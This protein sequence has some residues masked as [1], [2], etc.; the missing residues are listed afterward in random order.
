MSQFAERIQW[1]IYLLFDHLLPPLQLFSHLLHYTFHLHNMVI[2]G[3]SSRTMIHHNSQM[4]QLPW[5]Q[6]GRQYLWK[7]VLWKI[8]FAW[9]RIYM[10]IHYHKKVKNATFHCTFRD[11]LFILTISCLPSSSR[12]MYLTIYISRYLA[13]DWFYIW[14]I[15]RIYTF[16]EVAVKSWF[17]PI[18]EYR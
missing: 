5:V 17:E 8:F 7:V 14:C 12:Y 15:S 16:S 11:V 4:Y 6:I 9:D 13:C 2:R 1:F 3:N 18:L 10:S